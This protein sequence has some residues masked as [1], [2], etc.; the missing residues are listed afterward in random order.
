[1]KNLIFSL[2]VIFAS[3]SMAS[4]NSEPAINNSFINELLTSYLKSKDALISG[5]N[6]EVKVQA[7]V[8]V[9]TLSKL[10]GSKLSKDVE[11][12]FEKYKLSLTKNANAF[13]A[14][15]DIVKQRTA[16]APLSETFFNF[17]KQ[18]QMNTDTLYYQFCPM[19]KAYWLSTDEK[20]ENPYYGKQMLTCGKVTEV[21][22]PAGK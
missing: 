1:M 10:D 20:I 21:L 18:G 9:S 5:N 6:Q 12:A 17:I 16:F 4:A 3:S 19:K 8:F 13:A 11:V 2:L 7:D 22:K 15:K 14:A